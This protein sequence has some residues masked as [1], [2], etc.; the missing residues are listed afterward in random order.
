MA[1]TVV[2]LVD[3]PGGRFVVLEERGRCLVK[4]FS[5]N[6]GLG[7]S[8]GIGEVFERDRQGEKLAERVPAQMAFRFELLHML[9]SRSACTRFKESPTIHQGHDRE[10]FSAGAQF[11]NG[12]KVGQI[13]AKDI[14]GN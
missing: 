9:G 7:V 14:A 2:E 12:E 8:E 11:E 1:A 10:H 3:F 13:I 4:S 5:K 6:L